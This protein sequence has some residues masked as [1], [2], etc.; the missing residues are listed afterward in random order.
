[1]PEDR[2]F[3]GA[4]AVLKGEEKR[5]SEERHTQTALN[6]NAGTFRMRV[7]KTMKIPSVSGWFAFP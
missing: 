5:K 7:T 2:T 1:M 6:N 4:P 3:C